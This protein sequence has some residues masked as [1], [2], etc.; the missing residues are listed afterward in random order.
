M[1][2]PPLV[3]RLA[4]VAAAFTLGACQPP[5]PPSPR[6]NVIGSTTVAIDTRMTTVRVG[7][8][9]IGDFMTDTLAATVRAMGYE[10]ALALVN[11]GAIRGGNLAPGALPVTIDAKLGKIYPAGALTDDDV[12]GWFPFRDDT[13]VLT[14]TGAGLKSAL[15]RGAAELPPDLLDD[16]GGPLLS[17]S[18]GSYTIDCA[19]QVQIIDDDQNIV[20]REGTRITRLEVGGVV[21]WDR[22]AGVDLLDQTRV[23]LTVNDFV[24]EGLDGHAAL[25]RAPEEARIP[26]SQL[27]FRDA[28]VAAVAA[29]SPIAPALA[30]RI[31][32]VGGCGAPLT[33]P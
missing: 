13:V 21:L 16:D 1:R 5:A 19:G 17:L 23:Q 10:V 14:V 6:G 4:S 9:A 32:I 11:A 28:L 8:S 30:S 24:A 22:D 2:A 7:E 15:E 31:T 20:L 33:V 29:S 27:D 25:A 18:G 12:R 3:V 26:F